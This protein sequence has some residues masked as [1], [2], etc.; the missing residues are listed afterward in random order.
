MSA[1]E[2]LGASS[3]TVSDMHKGVYEYNTYKY[4]EYKTGGKAQC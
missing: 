2:G 1:A 4:R 3:D